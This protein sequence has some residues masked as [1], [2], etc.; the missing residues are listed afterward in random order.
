MSLYQGDVMN[1]HMYDVFPEEITRKWGD[2]E[3]DET[4][5]MNN[6]NKNHENN[7]LDTTFTLKNDDSLLLENQNQENSS[8]KKLFT[9]PKA[10]I[11]GNLPFSVSTALVIRWLKEMSKKEGAWSR[12][13]VPLTLTFQHE[14]SASFFHYYP[15]ILTNFLCLIIS[16]YIS[17]IT[18]L[19][20]FV[21]YI[22]NTYNK[23]IRIT[24]SLK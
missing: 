4:L 20:K 3:F 5:V 8:Q 2:K 19:F 9:I 1:F 16:F 22:I 6:S 18:C 24:L 15:T 11:I 21:D 23:M 12:G 10:H 14:V 17:V 7:Y 13:R